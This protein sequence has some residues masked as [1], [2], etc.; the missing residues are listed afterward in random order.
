MVDLLAESR[1]SPRLATAFRDGLAGPRRRWSQAVLA[2]AVARG[3]I[4]PVGDL[5]VDLVMDVLGRVPFWR[6][7][8]HGADIDDEQVDGLVWL[9]ARGLGTGPPGRG[10]W[11]PDYRRPAEGSSPAGESFSRPAVLAQPA[12]RTAGGPAAAPTG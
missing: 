1:R 10:A 5:D 11:F 7:A 4:G 12:L 6:L 9:V 2:R 8:V 3:E